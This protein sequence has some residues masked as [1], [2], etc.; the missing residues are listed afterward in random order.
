LELIK[1]KTI[2]AEQGDLF[3]EIMVN[4]YEELS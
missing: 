1:Q 4:K 3:T 2:V